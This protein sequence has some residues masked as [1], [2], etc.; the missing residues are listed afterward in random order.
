MEA[1]G[2]S[3]PGGSM[4]ASSAS[5]PGGPVDPPSLETHI[6]QMHASGGSLF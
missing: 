5:D 1:S 6:A 4:E 3:N 2:V